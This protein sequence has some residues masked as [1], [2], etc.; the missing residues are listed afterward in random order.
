MTDKQ[1]AE[2]MNAYEAADVMGFGYAPHALRAAL[3]AYEAAQPDPAPRAYD[4]QVW[5][6]NLIRQ[7]PETHDGRN[8]WL[9]N[10]GENGEDDEARNKRGIFWLEAHRRAA[11]SGENAAL[12]SFGGGGG[13]GGG[14]T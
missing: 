2:A 3:E 8:S 12:A 11:L 5:A 10:F 14:Q 6:A 13:G 4:R 1:F 7:L 9:L